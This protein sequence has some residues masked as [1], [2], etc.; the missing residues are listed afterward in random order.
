[1]WFINYVF[2][3]FS[4]PGKKVSGSPLNTG[5]DQTRK[6]KTYHE[7]GTKAGMTNDGFRFDYVKY[8]TCNSILANW[9]VVHEPRF[10]L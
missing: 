5:Q 8:Q 3:F 10:I 9:Y 1:M 6:I 4:N 7:R 2:D